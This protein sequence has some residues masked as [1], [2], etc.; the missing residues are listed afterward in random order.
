MPWSTRYINCISTLCALLLLSQ[1]VAGTGFV[2]RDFASDEAIARRVCEPAAPDVSESSIIANVC[3]ETLANDSPTCSNQMTVHMQ[4]SAANTCGQYFDLFNGCLM[5]N[6]N[7]H[8]ACSD[9][10]LG[11]QDCNNYTVQAYA[12][13][14]C[15]YTLPA[16]LAECA[17]EQLQPQAQYTAMVS[18]TNAPVTAISTGSD[19]VAAVASADQEPTPAVLAVSGKAPYPSSQSTVPTDPRTP[20]APT[21]R[22]TS[23]PLKWAMPSTDLGNAWTPS[24]ARSTS[25]EPITVVV[26]YATT[27]TAAEYTTTV[28]LTSTSITTVYT[29]TDGGDVT[30]PAPVSAASALIGPAPIVSAPRG[31]ETFAP[32]SAVEP[33][34]STGARIAEGRTEQTGDQVTSTFPS[35]AAPALST[36]VGPPEATVGRNGSAVCARCRRRSKIF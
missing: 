4:Q 23:L 22:I 7:D 11:Y 25:T 29:C 27:L 13:C 5:A 28:T 16:S 30:L 20:S 9:S 26:T 31:P 12:Y 32:H 14:G 1:P 3:N 36:G 18:P 19:T 21:L 17:N 34:Q 8:T 35:V 10:L 15:Y 2:P 24:A 6:N 33:A